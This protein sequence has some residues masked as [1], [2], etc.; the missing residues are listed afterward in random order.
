MILLDSNVV[1]ALM[2]L[3]LEPAVADWL[4]RQTVEHLFISTPTVFEVRFGIEAKPQGRR[5]RTLEAAYDDVVGT[6]FCS[7]II[8]FGHACAIAAGQA[9]ARQQN[10]GRTVSIPDSQIAGIALTLGMQLAT[11]HIDDFAGLGVV[12]IDPWSPNA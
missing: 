5:R 8:P 7:R 12:L 1:S 2:R 11:R 6:Q 10:R 4:G 9:R 3:H